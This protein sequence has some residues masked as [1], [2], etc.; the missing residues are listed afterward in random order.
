M[1][2]AAQALVT[3]LTEVEK[4]RIRAA[5]TEAA[6][7]ALY[8]DY[9]PELPGGHL[10]GGTEADGVA[11]MKEVVAQINADFVAAGRTSGF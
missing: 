7:L 3:R 11:A 10:H 1:N 2:V 8:H 4:M 9:R 6:V 5:Q